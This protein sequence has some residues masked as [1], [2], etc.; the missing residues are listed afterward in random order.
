MKQL[1]PIV[2]KRVAAELRRIHSGKSDQ[3][4]E[5]GFIPFPIMF[6]GGSPF[7]AAPRGNPPSQ[8][9]GQQQTNGTDQKQQGNGPRVDNLGLEKK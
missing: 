5:D 8:G 6:A 7:F 1:T 9:F 4:E 2:E 3:D